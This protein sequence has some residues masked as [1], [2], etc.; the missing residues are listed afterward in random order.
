M[1]VESRE[2]YAERGAGAGVGC[3]ERDNG[4]YST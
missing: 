1:D 2:V 3:E 4:V